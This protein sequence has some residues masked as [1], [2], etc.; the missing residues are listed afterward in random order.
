MSFFP[1]QLTT[2]NQHKHMYPLKWLPSPLFYAKNS[3]QK[4]IKIEN[5]I[6][7]K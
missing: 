5:N 3:P 1:T 7:G 4:V 6:F 2:L